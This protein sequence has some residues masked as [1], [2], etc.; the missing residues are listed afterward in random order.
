MPYKFLV[1]IDSFKGSISSIELAKLFK[2]NLAG[3]KTYPIS[4]GG[5]GFYETIKYY[6]KGKEVFINVDSLEGRQISVPVLIDENNNAY[7]E[8]AKII[9]LTILQDVNST[10]IFDRSSF[11]LGQALIKLNDFN[12]NKLF[13][14]LGG[15]GT[16]DLGLGVLSALG[17]KFLSEDG[18]EIK[19]LN[20]R[21]AKTIKTI[22]LANIT[23]LNYE[24]TIVNDCKNELFGLN[25]ANFV[26]AHQKGAN[27]EEIITLDE[28]FIYLNDL[29]SKYFCITKDTIGDGSAGGL[30]YVFKHILHANYFQGIDFLLE[31]I[32]FDKIKNNFDY[33]ISGEG[34]LDEQSFDGKV[35]GGIL[36]R[37][38]E[39]WK[40]RVF[41]FCGQNKISRENDKNLEKI[42]KIYT[43]LQKHTENEKN[44]IKNVKKYIK[45][46]ITELKKDLEIIKK[47]NHTFPIFINENSKILILGSFP[48]V[49]SREENFYY[50]NPHNRF[51]SVLASVFNEEI[52]ITL[53]DKKDFLR[54]HNIALYDVIESCEI[55]GSKDNSILNVV[56]IDLDKIMSK[57]KIDKI[58]L[59]GGK[60]A[61]LFKKYFKKYLIF[62]RILPSTSPL[63]ANDK[64]NKLVEVYKKAILDD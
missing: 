58:I 23:K 26:Y 35:V 63:N 60:A 50:M 38:D 8:S 36:S 33:I 44:A 7:L 57:Y 40:N 4:D 12:I 19:N 6:K 37:L 15:S 18:Q 51:Y 11:G 30:G 22:D 41:L 10:N 17:Y 16:S 47:V 49:K 14:G 25:G 52:P 61:S 39:N 56:P 48:S 1:L 32:N 55:E 3:S 5:D 31:Q 45:M 24:I 43:I 34:C 13:L 62:A 59:N 42:K 27:K 28:N 20:I 21:K 46:N 54:N 2:T 29:F 53:N 9:G 64:L